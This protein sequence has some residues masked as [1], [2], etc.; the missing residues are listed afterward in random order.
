M[1]LYRGHTEINITSLN[2]E[3]QQ[4]RQHHVTV[5]T[6]LITRVAVILVKQ[7]GQIQ[8][9]RSDISEEKL[10]NVLSLAVCSVL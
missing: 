2:I 5:I 8:C 1:H 7:C 6:L 10:A 9:T 3:D 4:P